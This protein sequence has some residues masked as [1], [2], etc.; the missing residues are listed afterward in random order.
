MKSS[1]RLVALLFLPLTASLALADGLDSP[2]PELTAEQRM[3]ALRL[4]KMLR[5]ARGDAEAIDKLIQRA[6]ELG[7][8]AVERLLPAIKADLMQELGGYGKAFAAAA[9]KRKAS[10]QSLDEVEAVLADDERLARRRAGLIPLGEG[11]A[12]LAA[13]LPEAEQP[14]QDFTTYLR[15]QEEGA[16]RVVR[17]GPELS[18]LDPQELIAI[19]E[20]NKRRI[21]AKLPPLQPDLQLVLAARDH[22]RDMVQRDFFSHES[23]AP[24][25]R[26]FGDRVRRFNTTASGENIYAGSESGAGAVESWMNSPPHRENILS[27]SATRIGVG[28]FGKKFTQ[29]FGR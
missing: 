7:P 11:A 2:P 4:P 13:A 16:L 15:E 17:L 14:D 3:E 24:G 6:L 9:Q 12:R 5:G 19:Q 28:R 29:L 20:T 27:E 8:M 23:P 22:S 25:K 21:A 10:G 26:T 1:S 18:Q